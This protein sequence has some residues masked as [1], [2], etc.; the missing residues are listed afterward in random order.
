M[1]IVTQDYYEEEKREI[2]RLLKLK[3]ENRVK[4]FE[5]SDKIVELNREL[6][7]LDE[8]LKMYRYLM[9]EN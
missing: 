3:Q 2:K 7:K 6:E 8:E 9:R 4:Y 5:Y 1:S